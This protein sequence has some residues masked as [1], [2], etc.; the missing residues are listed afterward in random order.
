MNPENINESNFEHIFRDVDCIVDSLDNMKT[1]YLVNR[2]CVKHR[3]PYVFGG[4][5][6]RGKYFCV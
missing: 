2:V 1:R 4:Y 5:R 6:T 3:I